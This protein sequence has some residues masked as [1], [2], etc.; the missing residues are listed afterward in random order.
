MFRASS[1]LLQ[2]RITFFTRSPCSLCNTAK[3]AVQN[4]RK[5]RNFDY[6]EINV[7]EPGQ[8]RWRDVYE[9]DTPV[10]HVDKSSETSTSSAKLMH[11]FNE[12]QVKKLLDEVESA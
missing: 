3:T 2:S 4:V 11:R 1:R 7:M 10:I 12:T 6:E 5:E 9:F 8:E